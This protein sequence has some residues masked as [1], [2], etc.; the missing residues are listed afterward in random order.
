MKETTENKEE[1][2]RRDVFTDRLREKHPDIE[3][4]YY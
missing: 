3:S 1:R 4:F 2:K